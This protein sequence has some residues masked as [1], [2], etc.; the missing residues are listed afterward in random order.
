MKWQQDS[1]LVEI[2]FE[3]WGRIPGLLEKGGRALRGNRPL[4]QRYNTCVSISNVVVSWYLL[5]VQWMTWNLS[6]PKPKPMMAPADDEEKWLCTPV[7]SENEWLHPLPHFMTTSSD[8]SWHIC[9]A[10]TGIYFLKQS[11]EL[12]ILMRELCYF[13]DVDENA[14]GSIINLGMWHLLYV[15]M[16]AV[17]PTKMI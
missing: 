4:T 15:E 14:D 2:L 10:V 3:V 17:F 8:P 1:I 6:L 13:V 11:R 9:H 12:T 5:S 16:L 7:S